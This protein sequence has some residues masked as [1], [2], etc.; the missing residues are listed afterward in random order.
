MFRMLQESISVFRLEVFFFLPLLRAGIACMLSSV[1]KV[2]MDVHFIIKQKVWSVCPDFETI[3]LC[4]CRK[5]LH[6]K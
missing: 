3:R 2:V 6:R 5:T 1:I 4:V